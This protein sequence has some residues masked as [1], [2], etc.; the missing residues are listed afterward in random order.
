[1]CFPDGNLTCDPTMDNGRCPAG[2][3]AN[4]LNGGC[5]RSAIGT[6]KTGRCEATCPVGTGTCEA[7]LDG[8]PQICIVVD[9]TR[10]LDGTKTMDKF[11]GPVCTTKVMNPGPIGNDLDCLYTPMGGMARHFIDVCNDGYEC[12]IKGMGTGGGFDSLGDDKCRRLC[13]KSG[14]TPPAVDGGI[15]TPPAAC[16]GATP[17]CKDVWGLFAT[18][19]PVGLCVP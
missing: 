15:G 12:Y 7:D 2:T 18:T 11:I 1:V 17:T 16:G 4:D 13:Y 9:E 19:N 3:D 6:G 14:F 5:L 8:N 10:N